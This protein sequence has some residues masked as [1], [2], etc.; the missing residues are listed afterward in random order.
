MSERILVVDDDP[1]ITTFLTRYLEKQGFDAVS[2][3][4]GKAMRDVL[5]SDRID[6]C[7]LDV[8]L[9]DANGLELTREIRETSNLPIIVLSIR[10]D[11]VDRIFGLEFGADDYVTKPFEPREL[12]ARIRS[13]LRRAKV[14]DLARHE[15][16]PG[17]PLVQFG[18]WIMDLGARTLVQT[19]TGEDAGLTSMEFDLL[20]VFVDKPRVVLTRDQLIDQARGTRAIIGDRAIDVHVMRLRKKIEPDKNKPRFIKTIH[21]IGYCFADDVTR[22]KNTA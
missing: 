5:A 9:P 19:K 10:D 20:K 17:T 11:S 21:G 7:V 18:P 8:G 14:E 13:V 2:V 15:A 3:G 4:T 1:Q 22:Y 12:V 16:E 6:L